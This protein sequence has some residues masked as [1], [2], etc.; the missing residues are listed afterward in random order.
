[1]LAQFRVFG[2]PGIALGTKF[3]NKFGSKVVISPSRFN[4]PQLVLPGIDYIR[5]LQHKITVT[6]KQ[7][8]VHSTLNGCREGFGSHEIVSKKYL[9]NI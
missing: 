5:D 4:I 6:I 2:C 1:M 7:N 9:I 3:S 8:G